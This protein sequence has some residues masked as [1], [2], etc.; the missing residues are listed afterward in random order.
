MYIDW[1]FLTL[2]CSCKR[3]PPPL[4]VVQGGMAEPPATFFPLDVP[5][6]TIF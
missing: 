5:Y 6:L 2:E 3:I 1:C 4:T